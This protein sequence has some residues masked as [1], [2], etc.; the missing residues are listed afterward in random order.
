MPAIISLVLPPLLSEI[1][2]FFE[3]SRKTHL[4]ISWQMPRATRTINGTN[5]AIQFT[6]NDRKTVRIDMRYRTP[7]DL[8][9]RCS[10]WAILILSIVNKFVTEPISKYLMYSGCSLDIFLTIIIRIVDVAR[11]TSLIVLNTLKL[12][13]TEREIDSYIIK[14]AQP[15]PSRFD[16]SL[17]SFSSQSKKNLIEKGIS[18]VQV[19]IKKTRLRL[20]SHSGWKHCQSTRK[21][22][23]FLSLAFGDSLRGISTFSTI[24]LDK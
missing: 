20:I 21:A 3:I 2:I 12:K 17:F 23:G 1:F 19:S 22:P 7:K 14:K 4:S 9:A 24:Q 13:I 5:S 16:L 6:V 10:A 15:I 11:T 18:T 8:W